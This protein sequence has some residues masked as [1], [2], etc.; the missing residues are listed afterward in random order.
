M[1]L[2]PT[3]ELVARAWAIAAV[4]GMT[5]AKIVTTLPVP[6]WTDNEIVQIVQVG[7]TPDPELPVFEPVYSFQCYATR[8]GSAKPP[9]GQ[10]NQLALKIWKVTFSWAYNNSPRVLLTMPVSGYG[11]AIVRT[12]TAVSQPRRIP[13]DPSQYA[14]YG[15][16]VHLSWYAKDEVFA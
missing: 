13:A 1:S 5:A 14:I 11:Q 10:A 16:D 6:P 3:D 2:I 9:W 4:P 12:A 8:D 15:V 7:G